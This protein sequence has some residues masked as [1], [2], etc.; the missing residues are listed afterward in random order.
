[1]RAEKKKIV[2]LFSEET[3]DESIPT[4]FAMVYHLLGKFALEKNRTTYSVIIHP[5]LLERQHEP[6]MSET[7]QKSQR[8]MSVWHTENA[9]VCL[10]YT[11]NE[12]ARPVIR[13][14]RSCTSTWFTTVTSRK[15]S[16]I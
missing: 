3:L 2:P 10:S 1:V 6:E 5:Q 15:E 12:T 14:S 4:I 11:E 16:N 8:F 7:T 9:T 13:K